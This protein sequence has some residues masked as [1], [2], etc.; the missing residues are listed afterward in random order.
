[1]YKILLLCA[2]I[3]T[4]HSKSVIIGQTSEQNGVKKVYQK[5][6]EASPLPFLKRKLLITFE[7]PDGESIKGISMKDLDNGIAEPSITSGG[8][9]YDFV[10]LKLKSERGHGYNFILEI[11]A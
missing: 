2:V 8:L 10:N 5:S 9:G 11:Y 6:I 3:S 7:H 1:M 4:V